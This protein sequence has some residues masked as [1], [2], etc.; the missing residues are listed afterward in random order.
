MFLNIFIKLEDVPQISSTS[1]LPV[2][3]VSSDSS[4]DNVSEELVTTDEPRA[5][6]VPE[7]V[8]IAIPGCF[9]RLYDRHPL[10]AI[11]LHR[12]HDGCQ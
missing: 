5:P 12:F 7:Y 6:K 1:A 11:S 9:S 2:H 10:T 3:G 4:L 8:W